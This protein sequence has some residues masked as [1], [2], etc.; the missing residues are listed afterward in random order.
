MEHKRNSTEG[1]KEIIERTHLLL[2]KED[3]KDKKR[4]WKTPRG[5]PDEVPKMK[6]R[7]DGNSRIPS[8]LKYE[9]LWKYVNENL[10][11]AWLMLKKYYLKN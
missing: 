6:I 4:W 3:I 11:F 10:S 7:N 9:G 1:R 5:I 2:L 8:T